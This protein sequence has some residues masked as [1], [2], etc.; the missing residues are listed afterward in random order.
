MQMSF[1][2]A[3]ILASVALLIQG[4]LQPA[5][6]AG[7]MLDQVLISRR[8]DTATLEV[9]LE[10]RNRYIDSFPLTKSE[11]VQINFLRVDECGLS[12]TSTP[13][14]EIQRP[15]GREMASL[16]EME[17]IRSGKDQEILL[18]RFDHPVSVVVQQRGDL[19]RLLIKVDISGEP[20]PAVAETIP[21]PAIA[22]TPGPSIPAPTAD[23]ISRAEERAR[24]EMTQKAVPAA[25]SGALYAI[26]LE[27]ALEPIDAR[28]LEADQLANTAQLYG[29]EVVV[30]G[31]TWYRLRLGFFA[32]EAEA[33]TALQRLRPGYP[34]AWIVRVPPDEADAAGRGEIVVAGADAA[35]NSTEW[36]AGRPP[37]D[38]SAVAQPTGLAIERISELMDEGR[39]ALLTGANDRAVQVYTKVLREPENEFSR[40]AQEYL[41]LARERNGQNAHAVAEYRRYLMLYPAGEDAARVGQRLNGL[42]A[43]D[44]TRAVPRVSNARSEDV[45]R[46]DM[47]GGLAQYYRRDAGQFGDQAE[48]VGQSSILSDF[49]FVARRRGDRFDFS[50]RA[51]VGYQYD[52]LSQDEG[53]GN[54]SRFYYLYTDVVDSQWD[55]SA[56]LGRQSLHSSGV[57]GRFDGAQVGWSVWPN[58]RLNIVTGYPVDSANDSIDTDRFFYGF[59]THFTNVLELFDLSMFYNTQDVDGLEDRQAVG[60]ELRYFD[61]SRSLI[62]LIDYDISYSEINSFVTLGNWAFPNRMTLNAMIDFRKSPLLTTRNALI[63]QT[64]T[65]IEELLLVFREDEI[66]QLARD[67]SGEMQTYSLG[68]SAPLFDRFQINAD[69]T[70]VNFDGTPASGGVPGY[71]DADGNIYYSMTLIGSS[72]LTAQ[73]TSILGFGYVDAGTVAT[74]TLTFDTRYPVTRGMRINPRLRIS[75]REIERTDSEQWI[76]APSL[77]FLYR[78]ARRFELELELGGEW[79]SQ[80]TDTESFDYNTYFIYGGYRADF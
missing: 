21:A 42:T 7:T 15:V 67:R 79:S 3:A 62:M 24:L 40:Q 75:R 76:A 4:I 2:L 38:T 78:F 66:R 26:N 10:C 34:D 22:A 52:L 18:L 44:D 77:R 60:S 71:P 48:V 80:E 20:S 8:G 46:W 31:R 17:F 43:V 29:T 68:L 33:E 63:G 45:S 5:H 35:R 64:V 69:A 16:K 50:S 25:V 23:Q 28:R 70:M 14:R 9:K 32:T 12:R 53:S 73:D 54:S 74:S 58:A 30:D 37:P 41:G 61:E 6:A 59:S 27:S 1:R 36:S 56:R 47:Y 55:L 19:S 49:D 39:Q 65:T 13:R 72:L 51:T 11:R 57:L